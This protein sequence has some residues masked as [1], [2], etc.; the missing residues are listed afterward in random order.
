MPGHDIGVMLHHR[1]DDLIPRLHARHGPAISDCID[2]HRRPSV[3]DDFVFV[4]HTEEFRDDAPR[5]LVFLGREVRQ[6][7]QTA[8]NI[9]VL[10][11][12]GP[13]DRVDHDLWLLRTR[14]VIEIDQR[15]SIHF[16]RQDRKIRAN[17]VHVI[18][19]QGFLRSGRPK[20]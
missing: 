2:P 12:I 8:V 11:A 20:G 3:H 1:Q 10:F 18:H 13:A 14:P 17:G 5:A 16:T 6:E 19:I 7:M 4:F 15:L 9:G